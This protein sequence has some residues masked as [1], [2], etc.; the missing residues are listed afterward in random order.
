MSY[1]VPILL[2]TFNRPDTTRSVFQKIRELQPKRLYLFSDAPRHGNNEDQ[3]NVEATRKIL[4]KIDWDCEVFSSFQEANLGCGIGVSSAINW[5]FEKEERALILEDDCLPDPSFFSFC[6]QMLEKY[7]DDTRIMHIAG[8]RWNEE[9]KLSG[10]SYFFSKISHIW[11]W[12]TWKRAWEKYDFQ[13]KEWEL[14]KTRQLTYQIFREK[15]I[16]QFW[17]GSFE[18]VF[19]Q[20][21]KHTWDYQWQ[22]SLFANNA[23]SIVP[24]VN[25]IS[26]IGTDGVHASASDSSNL[27]RKTFSWKNKQKPPFVVPYHEYDE[28]H[29]MQHFKIDY[30]LKKK[31]KN[32]IKKLISRK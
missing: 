17:D 2:I 21:K 14:Y 26:N 1:N 9:F 29:M 11:G 30:W 24:D 32:S 19:N 4:Q 8:T 6:E 23:L 3:K 15:S 10:E 18:Y 13:M 28:Y 27:F 7:K 22:F 31:I 12:A 20:S 5:V 16:A 25:L